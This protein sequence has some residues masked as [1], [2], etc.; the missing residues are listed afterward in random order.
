MSERVYVR[1]QTR[2]ACHTSHVTQTYLSGTVCDLIA[3]NIRLRRS[4]IE[5]QQ[6]LCETKDEWKARILAEFHLLKKGHAEEIAL[7]SKFVWNLR[8]KRMAIVFNTST[9]D[10]FNVF[11]RHFGNYTY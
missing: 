2:L 11:E 6:T 9:L 3:N 10:L 5:D 7:E 4:W 1:K 8:S